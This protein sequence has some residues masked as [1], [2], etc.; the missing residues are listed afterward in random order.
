ML[1]GVSLRP[2]RVFLSHTSELRRSPARRSFV[3]GQHDVA[4]QLGEDTLTRCRR[5]LGDDHPHTLDSATD[6]AA[7]AGLGQDEQASGLEEWVRSRR[8][9]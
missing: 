7:T 4:R 2:R 6:L 9:D 1:R 8:R 3:A 5:I